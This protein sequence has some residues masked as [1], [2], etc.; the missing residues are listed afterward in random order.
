MPQALLMQCLRHVIFHIFRQIPPDIFA[1]RYSAFYEKCPSYTVGTELAS[2]S[3]INNNRDSTVPKLCYWNAVIADYMRKDETARELLK[4]SL[5][6]NTENL[7]ALDF[8]NH[9]FLQ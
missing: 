4:K 7:A 3:D 6:L 9:G 2:P 5:S 8:L 1:V